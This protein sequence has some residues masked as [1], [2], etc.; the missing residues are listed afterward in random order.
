M[1]VSLNGLG[2]VGVVNGWVLKQEPRAMPDL[3]VGVPR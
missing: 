1:G 2:V 3:D